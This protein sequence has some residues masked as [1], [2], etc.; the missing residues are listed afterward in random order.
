MKWEDIHTVTPS[1]R[2]DP[3]GLFLILK[4]REE[5]REQ[6]SRCPLNEGPSVLPALW[7]GGRALPLCQS[8]L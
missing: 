8:P 6:A 3:D 5:K 7:L 4:H 2:S 1:P